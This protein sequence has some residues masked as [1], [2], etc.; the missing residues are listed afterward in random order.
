MW[1]TWKQPNIELAMSGCALALLVLY[2]LEI[3]QRLLE[4][5]VHRI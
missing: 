3:V 1:V 2:R 4:E 5:V